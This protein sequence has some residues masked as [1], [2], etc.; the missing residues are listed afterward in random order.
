MAAPDVK[1]APP[2]PPTRRPA[3]AKLALTLAVLFITVLIPF[4]VSEFMTIE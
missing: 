4:V 2:E 1:A 3:G